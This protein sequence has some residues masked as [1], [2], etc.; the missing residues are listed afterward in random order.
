MSE[1]RIEIL[2][3]RHHGP[4]SARSVSAALTELDPDLVLIEGAPEL[5]ALLPFADDPELVPPVAGLVYAVDEPRQATF[6]PLAS[7]SP[8]WVALSWAQAHRVEVR[9]ADL[10]ATHWLAMQDGSTP[11]AQAEPEVPAAEEDEA[12]SASRPARR[13][14]MPPRTSSESSHGRRGTTTPSA[15]GRTPSSTGTTARSADF[16]H[17]REAIALVRPSTSFH[18]DELNQRRE[19][20]MRRAL[21]AATRQGRQRI[22]FVCGAF[23]APALDPAGFPSAAAD[24]KLLTGLPKVKVSATWVPWTSNRLARRSGYGAGV[25]APG[26]YQHLFATWATDP[27][28][29]R[30]H[31]DG[32]GGPGAAGGAAARATGQRGRG[33]PPGRCAGRDAGPTL[34]GARGA[35]RRNPE[36]PV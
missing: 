26:W 8:E 22:A 2:G 30:V 12:A 33:D 5:D 19:A 15:G 6:Y 20:A 34:R 11:R 4:G 24:N 25:T 32:A 7:F 3:I 23:H 17:L 1:Q 35:D 9:F 18:D 27:D 13:R 14:T 36:R 21:R 29:G 31:L 10:A 16:A 28:A